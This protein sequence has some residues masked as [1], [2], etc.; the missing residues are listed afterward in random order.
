M[1]DYIDSREGDMFHR[2]RGRVIV[3]ASAAVWLAITSAALAQ[4]GSRQI[5]I[6]P[7]VP[8]TLVAPQAPAGPETVAPPAATPETVAPPNTTSSPATPGPAGGP[9]GPAGGPPGAAGG[10]PGPAGGPP[11][12]AA[13]APGPVADCSA[14]KFIQPEDV[15]AAIAAD[16]D[17]Q[18]TRAKSM[19]YLTLTHFVNVCVPNDVLEVYRQGAIKLVNSLSRSSEVVKVDPIDPDGS[20]LRI[21]LDDLGWDASDWDGLI[22]VYPYAAQPDTKLFG[23]LQAA[24]DTKLAYVR[25]DWFAYTAA[26]PPLY[27]ALLKLPKTYSAFAQAQGVDVT[28]D[29][30]KFVAQ[31]VGFQQSGESPNNR[32]IERHPSRSGYFWTS[33]NFAGNRARQSVFEFPIGPGQGGFD[34]DGTETAYSLPNGFVGYYIATAKGDAIDS[35]PTNIVRDQGRSDVT[36][37]TGISCMG[38]HRE[39]VRAVADEVRANVLGAH[40]FSKE[41]R[42]AVEAL[43]PETSHMDQMFADDTK[44][45]DA[46]M[47][48][49]GLDPTLQ[50]NNEEPISALSDR[51]DDLLDTKLAAA[52]LA[53]TADDFVSAVNDN[54]KYR[55]LLNRLGQGKVSRGEFEGRFAELIADLTDEVMI[56]FDKPKVVIVPAKPAAKPYTPPATSYSPPSNTYAPRGRY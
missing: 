28:G 38:C 55:P 6:E 10:P 13:G 48:R 9:P 51:F 52:E 31:R 35:A 18:R 3:G 54:R 21:N 26:R 37:T 41:V 8:D 34:H 16:L 39:G 22:A 2:N 27:N 33:Y 4:G 47:A 15:V 30:K 46:A 12:P 50:L 43:Y 24:T 53:L 44:R 49:A 5:Q 40:N 14:H 11:G 1:D 29:I 23:V 20:I 7:A 25:A 19:R 36:I 42:D 45:F 56:T 17:R 32:L